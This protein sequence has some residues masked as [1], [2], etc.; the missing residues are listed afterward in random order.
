MQKIQF[1]LGLCPRLRWETLQRSP[2]PSA[3]FR[4]KEGKMEGKESRMEKDGEGRERKGRSQPQYFGL[5]PP[6]Y[7]IH[8]RR[9][10]N[11]RCNRH[12]SIF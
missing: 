2:K 3:V 1:P 9:A 12:A 7:P 4:R 5:E 10:I 11:C 6:L 8:Q